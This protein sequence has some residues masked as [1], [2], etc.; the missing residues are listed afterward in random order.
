MKPDLFRF[1]AGYDEN[2]Y[3]Q[4]ER[5]R[6]FDNDLALSLAHPT[7]ATTPSKGS[8]AK[9][10]SGKLS[11]QTTSGIFSK[12]LLAA[13]SRSNEK[14]KRTPSRQIVHASGD[15]NGDSEILSR[16]LFP[17][18]ADPRASDSELGQK[19]MRAPNAS[20]SP[21]HT[22]TPKRSRIPRSANKQQQTLSSSNPTD[23]SK[24]PLPVA[25]LPR[26]HNEDQR[27]AILQQTQFVCVCK[28]CWLPT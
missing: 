9:K 11:V 16:V 18:D 12:Q 28:A 22:F 14:K 17:Q 8:S 25:M 23:K 3:F 7:K 2:G 13:A 24:L 15:E 6:S 10:P 26:I 1:F 19:R 4:I 27:V 5:V 21:E 20:S